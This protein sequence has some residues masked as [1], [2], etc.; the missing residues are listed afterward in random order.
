MMVEGDDFVRIEASDTPMSTTSVTKA[1]TDA[2][3]G[4]PS[5]LVSRESY[6]VVNYMN[7]WGAGH[8]VAYPVD[9]FL[10]PVRHLIKLYPSLKIRAYYGD[11][12][13]PGLPHPD[14]CAPGSMLE[15]TFAPEADP[16]PLGAF[17]LD[18]VFF[19][20]LERAGLLLF[21][22]YFDGVEQW[23]HTTGSTLFIPPGRADP[24]RYNA[25][26]RKITY[27]RAGELTRACMRNGGM[28]PLKYATVGARALRVVARWEIY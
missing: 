12:P 16:V 3:H 8:P 11:A 20:T 23:E 26:L 28:L 6:L 9:A 21:L 24:S 7:G 27:D 17:P 25:A 15:F 5:P 10:P 4:T 22:Q 2:A 18:P 1:A 19:S 14:T 13:W